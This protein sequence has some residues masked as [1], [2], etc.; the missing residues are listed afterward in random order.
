MSIVPIITIPH[1]T[2][3][4]KA[5]PVE[6]VDGDLR[7]LI[8]DLVDTFL[9]KPNGVGLAANQ[10]NVLKRFLVVDPD[11]REEGESHPIVMIN[12]EI[13]WTSEERSVYNEGCFSVPDQ[14]A[15]VER[16][17]LIRVRFLDLDGKVQ[18]MQRDD[19]LFNHVVQ[20]EMDH[21]DGILFVDHLSSLK[22]NIILRK[23]K[24]MQRDDDCTVL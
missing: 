11:R 21:L 18:E 22:R 24:R 7:R 5:T 17:A 19:V 15:E 12:P 9:D 1:P 4:Q 14:Y 3:R 10:I 8:G 2:L 16:P 23:L 13:I 20:H 6:K